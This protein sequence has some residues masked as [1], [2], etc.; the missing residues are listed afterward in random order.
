MDVSPALGLTFGR[1][2]SKQAG[3]LTVEVLGND[4]T[5]R[6]L[7]ILWETSR[8]RQY[9]RSISCTHI[10]EERAQRQAVRTYRGR[11]TRSQRRRSASTI[12][13][14]T[15]FVPTAVG[16][17][18]RIGQLVADAAVRRSGW[19]C[20]HAIPVPW[21]KDR[22][23]EHSHAVRGQSPCLTIVSVAQYTGHRTQAPAYAWS[24]INMCRR[25]E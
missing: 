13:L 2:T 24:G 14:M 15:P 19:I 21:P 8:S 16:A 4:S 3:Q 22:R 6:N 23:P 5:L 1:P 10:R 20:S 11:F 9:V 12:P 17:D 25:Q 7:Q 18:G